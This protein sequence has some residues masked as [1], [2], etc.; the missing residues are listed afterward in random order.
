[1]KSKR[2]LFSIALSILTLSVACKSREST[3]ANAQ[4]ENLDHNQRLEN[5]SPT[6]LKCMVKVL[7]DAIL[8]KGGGPQESHIV[9]Y[10]RSTS[11]QGCKNLTL[12]GSTN[13]TGADLIAYCREKVG[14]TGNPQYYFCAS[15]NSDGTN[16]QFAGE[17]K[18]EQA[19]N[20][21]G[22]GM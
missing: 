20:R 6:D 12:V 17:I 2:L 5:C 9:Y 22:G 19:C 13:S 10:F 14:A 1:M 15:K 7:L 21:Y 16:A 4:E 18:F 11:T 3:V 8:D